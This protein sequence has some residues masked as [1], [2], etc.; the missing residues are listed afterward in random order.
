METNGEGSGEGMEKPRRSLAAEPGTSFPA[1]SVQCGDAFPT[2]AQRLALC[3][4]GTCEG[5]S[6]SLWSRDAHSRGLLLRRWAAPFRIPRCRFQSEAEAQLLHG[7][8]LAQRRIT[9]PGFANSASDSENSAS[10]PSKAT[11]RFRRLVEL[12]RS[13]FG[14]RLPALRHIRRCEANH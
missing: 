14:V 6:K 7:I 10:Q 9:K 1:A 8:A 13:A 12:R 4:R 11:T 5:N 2:N 3:R